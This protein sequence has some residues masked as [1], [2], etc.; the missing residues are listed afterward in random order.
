MRGNKG[1]DGAYVPVHVQSA[2]EPLAESGTNIFTR[3]VAA[4]SH[5]G[6]GGYVSGYA[7]RDDHGPSL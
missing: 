3:H 1:L 7:A 2:I 4:R 6:T 5:M